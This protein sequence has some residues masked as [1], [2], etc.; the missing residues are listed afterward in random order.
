MT[1]PVVKHVT[2]KGSDQPNHLH[3]PVGGFAALMR[4]MRLQNNLVSNRG[5]EQTALICPRIGAFSDHTCLG[6]GFVMC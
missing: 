3:S 2:I 6:I 4:Y 1:K 5:F